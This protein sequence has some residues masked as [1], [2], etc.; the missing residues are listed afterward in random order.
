MGRAQLPSLIDAD[1]EPQNLQN[2]LFL[3]SEYCSTGNLSEIKSTYTN[4]RSGTPL[5]SLDE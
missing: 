1:N 2:E 5:T 4:L 3:N